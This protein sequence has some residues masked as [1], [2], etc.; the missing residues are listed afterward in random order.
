MEARLTTDDGDKPERFTPYGSFGRDEMN[1]AEFPIAALGKRKPGQKTLVFTDTIYGQDA[2]PTT[3]TLTITASDAW[4]L[5][6][7]ADDEMILGLI[8]LTAKEGFQSRELYFTRYELIKLLGWP[9]DGVSYRRITHSLRLWRAVT[10]HYD[11]AWWDNVEKSWVSETFGIIDSVS[12]YD[13]DRRE[14]RLKTNPD[15]PKA[16]LSSVEWGRILFKSFQDGNV[17]NINFQFYRSLESPLSKRIFRFLDKRLHKNQKLLKIDI[18]EFA[19][20]HVGLSRCYTNPDLK[21]KLLPAISEL[22]QR[23]FIAPLPLTERF[24][25]VSRGKWEVTFSRASTEEATTNPPTP[26]RNKKIS[27]AKDQQ[28]Q[29]PVPLG[30]PQSVIEKQNYQPPSDEEKRRAKGLVD[31]FLARTG[32]KRKTDENICGEQLSLLRQQ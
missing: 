26:P 32:R 5:P 2:K 17:K 20:D 11:K 27:K 7:S 3:R 15:D 10:L 9:D 28:S 30:M 25:Q 12:I 1:F 18:E 29:Y 4:G 21:R 6:T 31:E 14:R 23:G 8:Q 22:E 16:G 19:C 13:R 24:R